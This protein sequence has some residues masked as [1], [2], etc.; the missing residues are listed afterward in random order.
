MSV[1]DF[2]PRLLELIERSQH[3]AL[4]GHVNIDGDSLGSMLAMT[5]YLRSRGKT[6]RAFVFEPLLD[7]YSFLGGDDLVEIY[8]ARE[9]SEY[10]RSAD[11]FM[12]FDFSSPARMPGLRDELGRSRAVKVCIDHHPSADPPGDINVH[13]PTAPATGTIVL[14]LLRA[15]DAPIDR[16]IAECLL[17]AI[18]TDT[19]WFRNTNTSP[20]VLRDVA[21]LLATGIDASRVYREVYQRNETALV[22]LIGHVAMSAREELEGRLLWS[23]IPLAVAEEFGVGPYETDEMLDL[24]RTGRSAEVVALFRE[25]SG[26]AVRVN[27]RST[28]RVDVGRIACELGG[29]GHAYAA[30]ATIEQPLAFAS[31]RVI[32]RLRLAMQPN[33]AAAVRGAR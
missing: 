27:L 6:V 16:V 31:E 10:V 24:L 2:A 19:G 29:G 7:R 32:E 20:A 28:G 22:R 8:D 12:M 18:A 5:H 23:R 25:M 11:G 1:R 9:A 17:V 4:T 26:G 21:D 13:V 3:F 33:P 30:G 14:D 15:F